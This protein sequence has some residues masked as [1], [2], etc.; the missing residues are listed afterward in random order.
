MNNDIY[1]YDGTS[2]VYRPK[3]MTPDELTQ[4]YWELY[5]ELFTIKSIIKRNILRKEMLKTPARCI[6]NM[7]VNL[8]YREQ[9][10]RSITPNIF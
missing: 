9:I 1:S 6:F 10:K 5:S 4:A 3:N 8:Y 7:G 2:A